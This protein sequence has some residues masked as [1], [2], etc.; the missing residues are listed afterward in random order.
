MRIYLVGFMGSGKSSYAKKLANALGY[1]LMDLDA[2][3]E[4]QTGHSIPHWFDEI[5]EEAFREKEAQLLRSTAEQD[6]LVVATGGGAAC[7]HNSMDW[8]NANGTT[9]YLKLFENKLFNRLWKG[10]SERPLIEDMDQPEL[11]LFIHEELNDRSVFYS[12]A[13][14]VILPEQFP[15]KYLAE[16]LTKREP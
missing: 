4:R 2:E 16:Q 8:M 7:F 12:A 13:H 9:V 10:K 15:P 1:N 3:I 5:G 11:K 14:F 6:D